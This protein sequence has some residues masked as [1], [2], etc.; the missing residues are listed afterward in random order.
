MKEISELVEEGPRPGGEVYRTESLQ[1]LER[2]SV[3]SVASL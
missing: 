1:Y 2:K 3:T